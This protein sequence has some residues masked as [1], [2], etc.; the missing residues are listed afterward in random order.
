MASVSEEIAA[1]M[2]Q[3]AGS[4]TNTTET[5]N[6]MSERSG[7]I[8]KA[9]LNN[10]EL[11]D[12]ITKRN[13]SVIKIAEEMRHNVLELM[14]KLNM[15]KDVMVSIDNIARQ[16]NLLSLNAA[17]EAARAGEAGRGF[18][19]VANEIKKLS[20]DTS[21]LLTSA[22]GLINEINDSSEVTQKVL[23]IR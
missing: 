14:D 7:E 20:Q 12:E 21:D 15:L 16:T 23:N 18:A 5:L 6:G 10:S 17:I 4:I 8:Y 3:V 9:T 22:G 13:E 19:V 2:T 1:S 11:L